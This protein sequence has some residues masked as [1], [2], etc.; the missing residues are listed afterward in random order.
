VVIG[1]PRNASKRKG[2]RQVSVRSTKSLPATDVAPRDVQQ[3]WLLLRSIVVVSLWVLAT[4]A[5]ATRTYYVMG[6]EVG[7]LLTPALEFVGASLPAFCVAV[8]LGGIWV[9]W[10]ILSERGRPDNE[11]LSY[12]SEIWLLIAALPAAVNLV[13]VG[14]GRE[15]DRTFWEVLWIA[16]WTG[17]SFASLRRATLS[18]NWLFSYRLSGGFVVAVAACA[19]CWWI[20][21]SIY[22]HES[23]LLGFNDFGHFAQ[24]VANTAEGRGFL[25]ETPVLP[26]FW[27]HFNPGLALLVPLWKVW[28]DERLFFVLQ[29]LSLA[30]PSLL[31]FRL[32]SN[33]KLSTATAA[34]LAIAWLL[35]PVVGQM[36]LAYT[37][38]WHPISLAIPFMFL[39]I[40]RAA[41][42]KYV[43]AIL[44]LTLGSAMEEGV[45]AVVA[46]FAGTCGVWTW[47]EEWRTRNR[48]AAVQPGSLRL[49][50]L[51][52]VHWFALSATCAIAFVAVF[53]LSGL[54]EFQTGRFVA[55]GNTLGEVVCSPVTKP[56]V[57]WPLLF[58]LKDW[59]FLA[60][61]IIP[62][63][64]NVFWHSKWLWLAI[65]PPVAV[66]FVWD[67]RP[68]TC[69]A[70]QYPSSLLPVMWLAVVLSVQK[71][72]RDAQHPAAMGV[73]AASLLLGMYLGMFPYSGD[74]LGDVKVATYAP[75]ESQ[76]RL[77]GKEDSDWLLTE[78][79]KVDRD[80]KVLA[81]GRI[82]AHLVG[83]QDLETVGQFILRR[84]DLELLP[85]RSSGALQHYDLII[86]DLNEQ[87]QQL[88]R[89]SEAIYAE[90]LAMG[91]QVT[92]SEYS[93]VFL[94]RPNSAP[95]SQGDAP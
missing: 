78:L 23:F 46:C 21:Q 20:A 14:L 35:Q 86:L 4:S 55:L 28:P 75:S 65:L 15:L 13:E 25:L 22:Y 5:I 2:G 44:A 42:H 24:R 3:A 40:E 26:A 1:N 33:L 92:R 73:L 70:F 90:A 57:F 68:A 27:D 61:L 38:G 45:I 11:V 63:G 30:L 91:Y 18:E 41:A 77:R 59:T 76:N 85:T 9:V 66:L 12:R 51:Q 87:F 50:G 56:T 94:S 6:Y 43:T 62:L 36:N 49:F 89:E 93:V 82:A 47:W 31:I 79:S 58:D 39:A 81:T 67:H 84:P 16:G 37:Y 88:T 34:T 72:P 8:L 19:A 48:P 29:A 60:C 95:S 74:T 54:A 83:C 71:S 69:L 80:S 10:R 32:A 17:V 7:R 53:A 64:V 52:A